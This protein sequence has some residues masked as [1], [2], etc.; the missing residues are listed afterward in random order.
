VKYR[1]TN[2]KKYLVT[3][4]A[5]LVLIGGVTGTANAAKPS[6]TPAPNATGSI[7][8]VNGGNGQAFDEFN[9]HQTSATCTVSTTNWD[10][11]GN[12]EL[13]FNHTGSSE[14]F[15]YKAS[16]T[17]TGNTVTG[18]GGFPTTG[19]TI[20][21]WVIDSGTVTGDQIT[22]TAHFTKGV[23]TDPPTTLTIGGIIASN[24]VISGNWSDNFIGGAGVG[25][26]VATSGTASKAVTG[27]LGKGKFTYSDATGINYVMNVKYVNVSGDESWFAGPTTSGNFGIGTWIFIKVADNGEPGVG[28]DQIWSAEVADETVAKNSVANKLNPAGGPYI[29]TSGNLQVN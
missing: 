25:E 16:L 21:E 19:E 23:E 9:A 12:Y 10:V 7:G 5:S 15:T 26:F 4:L 29:I 6:V 24:G 28:H 8:W 2:I 27:C 14:F 1:Y 22:A 17:Q 13:T 3:G 18:S 11:T 20:F